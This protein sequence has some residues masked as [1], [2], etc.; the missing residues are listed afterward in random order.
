[1]L[2]PDSSLNL[3]ALFVLNIDL[4]YLV[5]VLTLPTIFVSAVQAQD[6]VAYKER[7]KALLPQ[8]KQL[9]ADNV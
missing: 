2:L 5:P 7:M 8:L 3:L 1:M 4:D 9:D 6:K